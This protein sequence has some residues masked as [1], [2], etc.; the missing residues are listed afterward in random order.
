MLFAPALAQNNLLDQLRQAAEQNRQLQQQQQARINALNLDL[1]NLDAATQQQLGQFR[2]LE[3]EITRLERERRQIEEQIG[4]LQGQQREA[5]ARIADL[6]KRL[7]GLKQRLSTLLNSLHR[8]RAARYLPLLRAQSFTD[9][10]VRSRWV[11]I[12]G[13]TQT[14]L[15]DQI[16]N[17]VRS[18]NEERDRLQLL[19]NNLNQAKL[20]RDARIGQLAQNQRSIQLVVANLRQ[21]SVGRQALLRETL[22]AQQQLRREFG[23]IQG[24][25]GSELRRIAEERRRLEA[26]RQARLAEERRRQAAEAARIRRLEEAR[27]AQEAREA[28]AAEERRQQQAAQDQ[29]DIDRQVEAR[30]VPRELVGGLAFPM[31]GGRITAGYG[32]G[33]NDY[34]TIEGSSA[35]MQVLAAAPGRVISTFFVSNYGYTVAIQHSERVI[36]TYTNLQDVRVSEGQRVDRRQLIGFT[37]GGVLI[38]TEQLW[39]QVAILND[40]GNYFYVNPSRYY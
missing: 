9:L 13:S 15:M 7:E 36:T 26:E 14:D 17:T 29:R 24:R 27:R 21:Q 37:G 19:V 8:E 12:L 4:L 38:P 35:G 40:D 20:E 34:Q 5:E 23:G 39:F 1:A 11:G 2:R 30:A 10:A 3:G 32:A 18:L 16:N 25:I 33:G 22:V 31:P 6:E 28:R